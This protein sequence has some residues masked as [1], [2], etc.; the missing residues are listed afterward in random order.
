MAISDQDKLDILWKKMIYGVSDTYVGGKAATEENIPSPITVQTDQIW[1]QSHLIPVPASTSSVV[2]RV[3]IKLVADPSVTT[4]QA[5]FAPK[6]ETQPI[7]TA[8]RLTD[9]ISFTKDPGY[10]VRVYSDA[11]MKTRLL[12]SESGKEWVFDYSAGILYFFNSLPSNIT[13]LYITGYRYVGEKGLTGV[14]NGGGQSSSSLTKMTITYI[15][16]INTNDSRE[17][18]LPTGSE[19]FLTDLEVSFPVTVESHRTSKRDDTF[20]YKFVATNSHKIDDGS[21]ISGG[22]RYYGPRHVLLTNID[23]PSSGS[24]YWKIISDSSN[25]GRLILKLSILRFGPVPEDLETT[26][27]TT[28]GNSTSGGTTEESL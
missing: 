5:W 17:F 24:S 23:N 4:R 3:E 15:V 1:S 26:I 20:Q 10:E 7:S 8:N 21:Y 2:E 18:T 19:F 27:D 13:D 11:E 28:I 14:G 22:T 6:D 9:F 12:P 25:S 16:D